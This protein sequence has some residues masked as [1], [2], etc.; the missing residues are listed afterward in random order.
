MRNLPPVTYLIVTIMGILILAFAFNAAIMWL[1]MWLGCSPVIV[2]G[3][4]GAA[5]SASF[6][7][8]DNRRK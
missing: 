8:K 2:A 1:L 5:H 4:V 6:L 3:I 7:L